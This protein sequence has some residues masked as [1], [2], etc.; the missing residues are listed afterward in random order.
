MKKKLLITLCRPLLFFLTVAV[1][2]VML[3]NSQSI[4]NYTDTNFDDYSDEFSHQ[5]ID[6]FSDVYFNPADTGDVIH[7]IPTPGGNSQALTWDGN[8]LWCSDIVTDSIYK[9]DPVDGTIINSFIFP[10]DLVEG[11][12]WDGT[13]LWASDNSLDI[14]YKFDPNDGSIISSLQL[15]DVWIH[16]ITW[17][18]Q[19]LWMNDFQDK[20]ILKINPENGDV[21]HSISAPG[22]GSIGLT[23]NGVHLWA[24][25]LF[26][27]KLYCLD[28]TDGAIIYEVNSPSSNPRDLAWDGQYLWVM[29]AITYRIY[30]VDVG[31]ST[32]GIEDLNL[33]PENIISFSVYPN[34]LVD[35]LSIEFE[36]R[37]KAIISIGIYDQQG[38][39]IDNLSKKNYSAGKHVV[40][41]NDEFVSNRNL[42]GGIYYC[43]LRS[44]TTKISKKFVA[45]GRN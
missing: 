34:P 30:Q 18:G 28:P 29:S 13:N 6:Q 23:W 8:Y 41:W 1:F 9:L 10:G 26:T 7:S 3:V 31:G 35:V 42:S 20:V 12:A 17:D 15:I 2:P 37:Q 27:D 14:I 44:E 36:V 45:A 24:D 11:L 43:I 21:L 25:D 32:T 19:Y 22:T 40:K 16:G 38:N 39:L 33:K 4:N 5:L